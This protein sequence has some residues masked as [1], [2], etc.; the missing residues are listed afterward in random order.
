MPVF[1]PPPPTPPA[2][3]DPLQLPAHVQGGVHAQAALPRSGLLV[4]PRRIGDAGRS[5][6]RRRTPPALL[7]PAG[8]ARPQAAPQQ[9]SGTGPTCRSYVL[10]TPLVSSSE[11]SSSTL[12][13]SP[14]QPR[15][16]WEAPWAG[17]ATAAAS[18]TSAA[19]PAPPRDSASPPAC[20]TSPSTSSIPTAP[21]SRSPPSRACPPALGR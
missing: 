21:A 14:L 16:C 7:H 18:R 10:Q 12:I 20:P 2:I 5:S 6:P 8:P 1:V 4:Q 3:S 19:R 13:L 11:T 15:R 9:R 17:A